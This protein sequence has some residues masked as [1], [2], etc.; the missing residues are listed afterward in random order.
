MVRR[1]RLNILNV[2]SYLYSAGV[3]SRVGAHLE[4]SSLGWSRLTSLPGRPS[5]VHHHGLP[6]EQA[7]QVGRFLS[8]YDPHLVE[9][10]IDMSINLQVSLL[11]VLLL[12]KKGYLILVRITLKYKTWCNKI[13]QSFFKV[14][15]GSHAILTIDTRWWY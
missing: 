11:C 15:K 1:L 6:S 5:L 14:R 10:Q 13:T 7:H 9:R 2:K 4:E 3:S 8:L 12:E